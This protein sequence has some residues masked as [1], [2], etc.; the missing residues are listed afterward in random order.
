[1]ILVKSMQICIPGTNK[2]CRNNAQNTSLNRHDFSASGAAHRNEAFMPTREEGG[3]AVQTSIFRI[4]VVVVGV[5]RGTRTEY[6]GTP[7]T[8]P[9]DCMHMHI[10]DHYR[11]L[12]W[13]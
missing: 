4:T 6:S 11:G 1:M 12:H 13:C 8:P 10:F 2:I 3:F 9:N 7:S 5:L